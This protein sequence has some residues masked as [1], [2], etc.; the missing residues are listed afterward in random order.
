MKKIFGLFKKKDEHDE[1]TKQQ[2]D[3]A[4]KE[5]MST[6]DKDSISNSNSDSASKEVRLEE[7]RRSMMER[8]IKKFDDMLNQ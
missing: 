1:E 3:D 6:K 8:K 2:A 7:I 4:N 5:D